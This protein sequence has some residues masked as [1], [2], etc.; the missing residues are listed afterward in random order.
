MVVGGFLASALSGSRVTVVGPTAAFIP[1]VAGV[2]HTYGT[3]GL[4]ACTGLA[5]L[6]LVVMGATGMGGIIR[7]VGGPSRDGGHR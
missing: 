2:A 4:V 5:G 3:A 7:W 1:I 6:M